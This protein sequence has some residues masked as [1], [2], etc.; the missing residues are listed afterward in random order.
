MITPNLYTQG[1][2]MS[3]LDSQTLLQIREDS[4]EARRSQ[5]PWGPFLHPA[6]LL[7]S[8]VYSSP[9]FDEQNVLKEAEERPSGLPKEDIRVTPSEQ[10]NQYLEDASLRSF[11]LS[12]KRRLKDLEELPQ[13]QSYYNKKTPA[14][15][16]THFHGEKSSKDDTRAENHTMKRSKL[17]FLCRKC[18]QG[19]LN[20]EKPKRQGR[21]DHGWL[22][23]YG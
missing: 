2:E 23:A 16:V 11:L 6:V 9:S 4:D 10:M 20:Q 22:I 17:P 1:D 18:Y 5:E 15:V 19:E 8:A 13:R 12:L 21:N 14:K 3:R 7:P